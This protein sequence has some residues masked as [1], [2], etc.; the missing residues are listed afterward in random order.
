MANSEALGHSGVR[1]MQ[2]LL[3]EA[4]DHPEKITEWEQIFVASMDDKLMKYQQKMLISEKQQEI[5][6]RIANKLGMDEN[7]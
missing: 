3:A 6:N 2:E 5:L 7:A 4:E 1:W